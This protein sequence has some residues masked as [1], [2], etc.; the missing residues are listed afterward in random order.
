M[1]GL[2]AD[3]VDLYRKDMYKAEREGANEKEVMYP[4]IFKVV[5]KDITGAGSKNYQMLSAG[6]LTRHTV[7]GQDI[8]FKSPIEG[9]TTYVKYHTYS[10]GLTFSPEAVED[11]QKLGNVLND[12]A[13][14]WGREVRISKELLSSGVF[15]NGGTLLGSFEFDGSYT[16]EADPSGQLLYDS[17]PFF[18][19][20]GNLRTTK[21]GGTYYNSVASLTMTPA[22]FET[23][24]NLMTA[25][26]NRDE[27]DRVSENPMD[28]V[29]TAPGA[30]HFLAN[31]ILLSE[32]LAGG[33]VNEI[34]RAHV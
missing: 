27:R 2:R 15:N 16:G 6:P 22:N 28:T 13:N 33:F 19:L 5:T 11:T 8:T 12:L 25:T 1:P 3:Q 10:D 29:L 24:Y 4:K 31:R 32:K 21:G 14:T 7:E 23:V 34:G 30:P 20:A 18:N 17:I 26:N 9:W